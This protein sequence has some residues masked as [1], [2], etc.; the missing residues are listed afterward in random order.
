MKIKQ[1]NYTTKD[2]SDYPLGVKSPDES[3]L[4][5]AVNAANYDLLQ[6][7]GPEDRVLEI[8]CGSSSFLK[9]NMKDKK[10]GRA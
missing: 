7:I 2:I 1:W 3:I 8:G 4:A 10:N 9:D 6:S 5:N